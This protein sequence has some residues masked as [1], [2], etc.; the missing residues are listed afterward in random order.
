MKQS[1]YDV[2]IIGAGFSGLSC[3]TAIINSSDTP[4]KVVVL[5]ARSRVGGRISSDVV[6][7]DKKE[8]K[9]D[10][11]GA[12]VG[13]TQDRI[14][15]VASDVGVTTY[16]VHLK[17]K[18]IQALETNSATK[19]FEGTIP[20]LSV[21]QLIDFNKILSQWDKLAATVSVE[22]PWSHPDAAQLDA[23]TVGE[24]LRKSTWTEVAQKMGTFMI[25]VILCKEPGEVSM[26][27]WLMYIKSG[28]GLMRLSDANNGAQERKFTQGACTICERLAERLG[29]ERILLDS[30]VQS[31]EQIETEGVTVVTASSG[32]RDA[33]VYKVK[34]VVVALAP[35]LYSKI[36]WK[37][38]LPQ[39]KSKLAAATSIGSIIKTNLYWSK[40]FWREKGL[41]GSVISQEGPV[42]YSYDDCGP[43]SKYN[44]IMGFVLARHAVAWSQKTKEER[45][46]ALAD[47][48]AEMFGIPE[49]RNPIAYVEKNWDLEEWSGGCYVGCM[50][51]HVLTSWGK[52]LR[53]KFERVHFAGT[54]TATKWVG[55]MDGAIE[56]GERSAYEVLVR[57]R[58]DNLIVNPKL[59]RMN[60]PP[61]TEVVPRPNDG[62][63][64]H[65]LPG[66]GG[67][68]FSLLV[69]LLA[70]VLSFLK[71]Y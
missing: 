26:L 60:E 57:L 45:K 17:G 67:I 10:T 36:S 52:G 53:D 21:V 46:Q 47:Q 18:T 23:Q 35:T 6:E 69:L 48:Y 28:Q 70:F 42:S 11:G 37:P 41:S 27:Y 16:P 58:D 20:L 31:I 68:F 14:L 4:P 13:P 71:L 8:V 33:H 51:P 5:E 30:P 15:R 63:I 59:P 7:V 66:V 49:M 34:Y 19:L 61:N 9:V 24:W 43:D 44:S 22:A 2:A 64:I 54:E 25:N 55:Y 62:A 65:W 39:A 1:N 56:A 3:A 32:S 38:Q 12:Y 40:P 29:S 50:P